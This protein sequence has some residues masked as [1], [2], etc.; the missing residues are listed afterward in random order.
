MSLEELRSLRDDLRE[1]RRFVEGI[2]VRVSPENPQPR[3]V[4]RTEATVVDFDRARRERRE[5]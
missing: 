5:Q 1:L 2:R 3:R 4:P